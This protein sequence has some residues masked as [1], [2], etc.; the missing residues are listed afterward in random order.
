[1]PL[2]F[3]PYFMKTTWKDELGSLTFKRCETKWFKT[4]PW[5]DFSFFQL[6]DCFISIFSFHIHFCMIAYNLACHDVMR[7]VPWTHHGD[8]VAF[9]FTW[10]FGD[11]VKFSGTI[12]MYRSRPHFML[13]FLTT[14]NLIVIERKRAL[15]CVESHV[16]YVLQSWMLN[17]AT[18]WCGGIRIFICEACIFVNELCKCRCAACQSC[19]GF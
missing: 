14:K 13:W 9:V 11:L 15:F 18:V 6:Y 10:R 5:S 16:I 1:M 7:E 12:K 4:C 3:A 17:V 2:T 19:S 8:I